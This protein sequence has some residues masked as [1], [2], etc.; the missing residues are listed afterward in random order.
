MDVARTRAHNASIRLEP[1]LKVGIS[2][3]ISHS[4]I[5]IR[6]FHPSEQHSKMTDTIDQLLYFKNKLELS[7][8][9]LSE[10]RDNLRRKIA[11]KQSETKE[12]QEKKE[13]DSQKLI[14]LRLEQLEFN[15]RADMYQ[16]YVGEISDMVNRI[17]TKVKDKVQ[18][19][20]FERDVL[21]SIN[22]FDSA[23]EYFRD[24][25]LQME[26]MRKGNS[27]RERR[28]ELTTVE[29]EQKEMLRKIEERKREKERQEMAEKQRLKEIEE[30]EKQERLVKS[31]PTFKKVP[32]PIEPQETRLPELLEGSLSQFM[33]W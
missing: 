15:R 19:K 22:S 9:Q 16:A 20:D 29:N 11:L 18:I 31:R 12:I 32:S 14:E 10:E 6:T 23:M 8:S 25:S 24:D 33:R 13:E 2:L 3:Q 27:V 30:Q 17:D 4:Q 21:K 7:I 26:L 28:V 5:L 1:D